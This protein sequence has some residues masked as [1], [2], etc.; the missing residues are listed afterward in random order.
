MY[1]PYPWF[2]VLNMIAADLSKAAWQSD[3][4]PRIFRRKPWSFCC[5]GC[6]DAMSCKW[7]STIVIDGK[8]SIVKHDTWAGYRKIESGDMIA[9]I[10]FI[11]RLGF[12][13]WQGGCPSL[14]RIWSMGALHAASSCFGGRPA[15][16]EVND[17]RQ[18]RSTQFCRVQKDAVSMDV[19][20]NSVSELRRRLLFHNFAFGSFG[21][22]ASSYAILQLLP[23]LQ[24][25][26]Q[27]AS[28]CYWFL[29]NPR[30]KYSAILIGY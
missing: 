11:K 16:S 25:L 4:E 2:C 10:D 5:F 6:L 20:D 13:K 26:H 27:S 24:R 8:Y 30:C 1:Y 14:Q 22:L 19:A 21:R 9:Y 18:R 3:R 29:T 17:L 28:G 15:Q 7:T 12:D 23:D